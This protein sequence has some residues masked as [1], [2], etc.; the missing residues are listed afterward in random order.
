MWL[1]KWMFCL[2]FFLGRNILGTE[3]MAKLCSFFWV[4][5]L[6]HNPKELQNQSQVAKSLD[7]KF[8]YCL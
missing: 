1:E 8:P 2:I 7:H 6:R 5:T 3:L 4:I